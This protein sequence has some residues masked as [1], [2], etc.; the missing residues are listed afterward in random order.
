VAA[1]GSK[2]SSATPAL[3]HPSELL[4]GSSLH[5]AALLAGEEDPHN[6]RCRR[7]VVELN[8]YFLLPCSDPAWK[9]NHLSGWAGMFAV[10]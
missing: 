7:G 5:A 6:S 10:Y 4:P 3:S 1:K 8:L 9:Y 2:R